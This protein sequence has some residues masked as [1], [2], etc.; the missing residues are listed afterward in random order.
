MWRLSPNAGQAVVPL[1]KSVSLKELGQVEVQLV[2]P[3]LESVLV[4]KLDQFLPD[5]VVQD[6]LL[7]HLQ[8]EVE[9]GVGV[10]WRADGDVGEHQLRDG[11]DGDGGGDGALLPPLEGHHDEEGGEGEPRQDD[12]DPE[13]SPEFP[14]GGDVGQAVDCGGGEEILQLLKHFPSASLYPL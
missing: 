1:P 6:R 13:H 9:G 7:G 10:S 2:V 14:G 8:E 4:E 11:L 3:D 12:T 5:L